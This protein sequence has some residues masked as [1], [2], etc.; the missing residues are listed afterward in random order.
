[1]LRRIRERNCLKSLSKNAQITKATTILVNDAATAW[2]YSAAFLDPTTS[3]FSSFCVV[4][5]QVVSNKTVKEIK[6]I[7]LIPTR[8]QVY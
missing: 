4:A 5:E 3:L 6:V 7:N 8:R 1:M 2:T